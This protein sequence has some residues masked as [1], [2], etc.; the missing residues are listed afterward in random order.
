MRDTK[1][2]ERGGE[3]ESEFTLFNNLKPVFSILFEFFA[4]LSGILK[5]KKKG[6]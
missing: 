5:R 3:G 4:G 6:R 2:L 1:G